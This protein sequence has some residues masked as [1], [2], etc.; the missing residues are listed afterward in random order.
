ML[1]HPRIQAL[2]NKMIR[3]GVMQ[4][5]QK[6]IV[7]IATAKGTDGFNRAGGLKLMGRST[8]R[9]DRIGQGTHSKRSQAV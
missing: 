3:L 9:G 5:H 8:G 2:Q 4:P 7:N 6:R 1:K